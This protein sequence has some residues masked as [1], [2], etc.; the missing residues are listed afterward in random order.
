M[1]TN[2]A[3]LRTIRKK[4]LAFS[5][6]TVRTILDA[7]A[8]AAMLIDLDL[9]VV[10]QGNR[11]TIEL[12]GYTRTDLE[13]MSLDLLFP[14]AAGYASL[15]EITKK[16]IST[17]GLYFIMN[18]HGDRGIQ[19]Q[20]QIS[21]LDEQNKLALLSIQ[22]AISPDSNMQE[23]EQRNRLVLAI[24]DFLIANRENKLPA[25]IDAVLQIVQNLTGCE[26]IAIY[27][28]DGAKLCLDRIGCIGSSNWM[29]G[30]L[31]H[32]AMVQMR[33]LQIWHR[34]KRAISDLQHIALQEGIGF[35][36]T[37]PLGQDD[38]W[39]GLIAAS[40]ISM[41]SIDQ[42]LTPTI[43]QLCAS[44]LTTAIQHNLLISNLSCAI[45]EQK[46]L[47]SIANTAK[48]AIND[49]MF[50][51]DTD[52]N[53]VDI[54]HSAE[55]SLGYRLDEIR[56]QPIDRI[57]VGN[58]PLVPIF[59]RI[60]DDNQA[61]P[62]INC[63]L[64][65]R[66]GQDFSGI[67]RAIPIRFEKE[68]N[69]V[70]VLI[71]D[72]SEVEKILHQKEVLEQRAVLGEVTAAFAHEVRNPINSIYTGLQLMQIQLPPDN[73]VQIDITRM[74]EDC[75]RLN[76]LIKTALLYVKPYEYNME[77][78]D[79]SQI[80]PRLLDGMRARLVRGGIETR[81]Q[82]PGYPTMIEADVRAVEQIFTNLINNAADAM[83]ALEPSSKKILGVKISA[84][85]NHLDRDEI[86]VSISDTGSG[87]PEEIREHIFAPYYTTKPGG[88]GIG[89]ALV[90]RSVTALK[91]S[92]QVTSIPGAT[93]FRVYFPSYRK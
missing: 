83:N 89:L 36:A 93:I 64:Y 31:N 21:F 58:T 76:D 35:L 26:T 49:S 66:D 61:L 34:R 23:A 3:V 25:I 41:P 77:P 27:Q 86:E 71:N 87:I 68:L 2:K 82:E 60:R 50:I 37:A 19:V 9:N 28:I 12:S 65:R 38:A 53:I 45:E 17:A 4:Y 67:V 81:F 40:N 14:Q 13:S 74:I 73:E 7:N 54:N 70:L 22:P 88:T 92:I 51:L 43:L 46:H 84:V 85:S 75:N 5:P 56:G 59:K 48:N 15:A 69:N 72:L 29:P 30:K 39:I 18:C 78:L 80:L 10:I 47:V 16:N 42:S 44:A 6:T 8:L 1:S 24:H 55:V 79:L 63:R 57:L 33:T 32:Q 52:L 11:Q 91:G 90:K 62:G 20:L